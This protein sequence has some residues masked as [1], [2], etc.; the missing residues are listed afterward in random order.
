MAMVSAHLGRTLRPDPAVL[1]P[2]T[3]LAEHYTL[4]A[5]SSSALSRLDT[6]FRATGLGDL[7][8]SERRFSAQDSLPTPISRPDPAVYL[9]AVARARGRPAGLPRDRGLAAR[10]ERRRSPPSV[11]DAGATAQSPHPLHVPVPH[12]RARP[13]AAA[14]VTPRDGHTP[15]AT[16]TTRARHRPDRR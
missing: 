6:C 11:G 14:R 1:G 5:V 3:R 4:A 8:P 15:R 13:L 9:F 7:L 10:R 12:R 2:L 16:L